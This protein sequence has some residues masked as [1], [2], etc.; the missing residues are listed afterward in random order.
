M[1]LKLLFSAVSILFFINL[2]AQK[3][4]ELPRVFTNTGVECYVYTVQ[5]KDGLYGIAK[6][7]DISQ[8][9]IIAL[10]PSVTNGLKVGQPLYIPIKGNS[11]NTS[12]PSSTP[13]SVSSP[14]NEYIGL[15]NYQ[16]EAKQTL[17]SIAKRF[18]VSQEDIIQY[19]P[20]AKTMVKTGE[21]LRIPIRQQQEQYETS[22]QNPVQ[23]YTPSHNTPVLNDI[24]GEPISQITHTVQQGETLFSISKKY[25][26]YVEDIINANPNI[27][28]TLQIG[29]TLSI[30]VKSDYAPPTFET[31]HIDK[32]I[33]AFK[34]AFLLPFAAANSDMNNDRFLEFYSGALLAINKAKQAGMSFEIYTYDTNRD[35]YTINE[36]LK[37]PE[38]KN[39]DLIVGPAFTNQIGAVVDF[40]NNNKI[41]ILVPFSSKVQG[42]ATN[43]YIFQFNPSTESEIN[44][45]STQLSS[46]I[47]KDANIIFIR[48]NNV[49]AGDDG[50]LWATS[51][52]NIL[53]KKGKDSQTI[54]WTTP[55]DNTEIQTQLRSGVKNILIFMTDKYANVQPYLS[56]INT[57]SAANINLTLYI[58]YSWLNYNFRNTETM[59]IS[60]FNNTLS[61]V[62]LKDYQQDFSKYFVWNPTTTNPRFD[63][64]GY[65]ITNCFINQLQTF[66]NT[67]PND[68]NS[69]DY[70]AGVQSQ[71]DFERENRNSG[72]ENQ[73]MYLIT[74]SGK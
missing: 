42:I 45:A 9:D 17:Y 58:R 13:P 15:V 68:K 70:S 30:P 56:T 55:G 31:L 60:P 29:Q 11:P 12:T 35:N 39:I 46:G 3:I 20:Q 37:K 61:A 49:E 5:A 62:D 18:G 22:L 51:L 52:E 64:L 38:M 59:Y 19:N 34:I 27:E 71:F 65:D 48:P 44:F 54:E 21:I 4:D 16:V 53:T 10:N 32:E 36:I 69:I 40:A 8:D 73:K 67:F 14:Q 50:F 74:V 25:N 6:K 47:Y 7:F 43:P 24:Y 63:L 2:S 41:P 28:S 26:V 1:K 66:G 23:G 57:L 72:F 33:T